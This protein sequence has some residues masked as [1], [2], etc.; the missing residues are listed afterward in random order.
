[1]F[2]AYVALAV[3]TALAM[4]AS[5]SGKLRRDTRVVETIN[6]RLGVPLTWFPWLAA[7]E[8]AGGLAVLIGTGWAPL[9]IAGA[10]GLTAYFVGAFIAHLRIGDWSGLGSPAIPLVLAVATLVTRLLSL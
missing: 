8:V 1:M 2:V 6:G 10:V 3:L 4:F 5:A 9:G 7:C